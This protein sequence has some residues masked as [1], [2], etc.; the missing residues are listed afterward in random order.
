[1]GQSLEEENL[2]ALKAY[3]SK[4]RN[5]SLEMKETIHLNEKLLDSCKLSEINKY[6]SK[7]DECHFFHG[8]FRLKLSSL[9]SITDQKTELSTEIG[10]YRATLGQMSKPT[11]SADVC[12]ST[13]GTELMDQVRVIAFIRNSYTPLYG[14]ACVGEAEAWAFGL[15]RTISRFDIHGAVKNT[16]TITGRSHWPAAISVTRLG[17][18]V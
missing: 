9:S 12:L 6:Q 5:L 8:S 13:S 15:D 11:L 14:V 2:D 10:D 16:V 17:E 7:F 3:H 1:M 4:I 18:L